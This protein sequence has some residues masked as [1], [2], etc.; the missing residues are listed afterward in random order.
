MSYDQYGQWVEDDPFQAPDDQQYLM[1]LYA[2]QAF[3][4]PGKT[5]ANQLSLMKS[6]FDLMGVNPV[7]LAGQGD[8]TQQQERFQEQLNP[9][10]EIYGGSPLYASIFQAVDNGADPITA[11]KAA[12]D[13]LGKYA[14]SDERMAAEAQALGIAQKYAMNNIESE[15]QRMQ[16]DNENQNAA[17]SFTKADGSKYKNAPLGGADIYGTASEYDLLG[18]PDQNQLM[19]QYA[20]QLNPKRAAQKPMTVAPGQASPNA[21]KGRGSATART[22]APRTSTNLFD[23]NDVVDRYTRM[24]ASK[25]IN[26]RVQQSQ[27]TRVR[28]DANNNLMRRAAMLAQL[29]QRPFDQ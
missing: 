12:I 4:V 3:Q 11:T 16:F 28:S 26:S 27:Q 14:S 13:Q 9:E 17:A 8:P 23:D 6:Q 20:Q 7:S 25:G 21:P 29:S 22:S 15:N 1:D 2:Q 5:P 10:R 19:E 18:R 24:A